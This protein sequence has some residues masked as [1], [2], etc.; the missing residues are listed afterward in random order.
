MPGREAEHARPRPDGAR[1]SRR[2]TP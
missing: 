2:T 1:R